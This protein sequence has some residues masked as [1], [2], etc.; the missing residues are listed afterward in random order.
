MARITPIPKERAAMVLRSLYEEAERRFGFIPNLFRSLAHRPEL[1]ITFAN[2]Y[3]ELW[4]GGV[5]DLRTKELAALR[6]A[7]LN[8]CQY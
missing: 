4:T 8:G 2:F 7:F 3:R 1:L 6:T 5:L